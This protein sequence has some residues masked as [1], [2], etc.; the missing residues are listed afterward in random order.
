MI[1]ML[2]DGEMIL[3]VRPGYRAARSA[4]QSPVGNLFGMEQ[5]AAADSGGTLSLSVFGATE[6][7][8][9]I[10]DLDEETVMAVSTDGTDQVY[11]LSS[12]TVIDLMST[13]QK[14]RMLE[15]LTPIGS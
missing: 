4:L 14:E 3:S 6:H 5:L 15:A 2:V 8:K 10:L 1:V 11:D 13:R 9:L 12:D 7:F